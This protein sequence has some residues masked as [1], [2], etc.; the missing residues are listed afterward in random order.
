MLL[1]K[2]DKWIWSN[3]PS[4]VFSVKSILR[5]SCSIGLNPLLSSCKFAWN[6]KIPPRIKVFT[7]AALKGKISVDAIS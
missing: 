3:D 1:D 7:W 4:G 5:T 2:E 6:N